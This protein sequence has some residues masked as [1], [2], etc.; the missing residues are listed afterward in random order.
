MPFHHGGTEDTEE[1]VFYPV[2]R[3]RPDKKA[4]S[5]RKFQHLCTH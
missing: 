5:L 3:R 2:G 4:S 1:N